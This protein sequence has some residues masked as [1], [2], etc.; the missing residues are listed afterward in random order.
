MLNKF[1]REIMNK[2]WLKLFVLVVFVTLVLGIA[3]AVKSPVAAASPD[4][5]ISQVYGGGG[6]SGAQYTHDF[7]ELFN[8]GTLRS[9]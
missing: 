8:R 4:I 6:N 1:R 7:V 3:P 2:H 5:V 9:R